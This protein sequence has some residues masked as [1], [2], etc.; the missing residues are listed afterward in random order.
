MISPR[1]IL[2]QAA[3]LMGFAS[4]VTAQI[5]DLP[6]AAELVARRDFAA[7]EVLLD[8]IL[9]AKPGEADALNLKG[10]IAGERGESEAA[11]GWFE[12]ALK[13]NPNLAGAHTNLGHLYRKLGQNSLALNSF[14]Q[15][16][17]LAP[18]DPEALLNA[19]VILADEKKFDEA[20]QTIL[21]IPENLRTPHHW[22]VLGSFQLSAGHAAEA[23][24]TY[25]KVL[26]IDPES[27]ETL[28][29]LSGLALKRGDNK[30]AWNFMAQ[31]RQLA[32]H[33]PQ[34]LYE[35]GYVCLANNYVMDAAAA[36]RRAILMED[37]RPE[38]YAGLIDA[39]MRT[40]DYPMAAPH[41]EK[42]L[43]LRPEDPWG[44]FTKGQLLYLAG[45]LDEAVPYL[46]KSAEMNPKQADPH[47]L[48]GRVAYDKGAN[49]TA[50]EHFLKALQNQP[51]H[52][53][54]WLRLGMLHIRK[55]EYEKAEKELRRSAEL[56]PNEALTHLQLSL[57]LA[58]TGRT[59]EAARETEVHKKLKAEEQQRRSEAPPPLPSL[60]PVKK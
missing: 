17:R 20:G 22:E 9:K 28:R 40:T 24:K 15:A 16:A 26:E 48:L 18:G 27:V 12:K 6:Y 60:K 1:K 36:F 5:S 53:P 52:A 13:A 4:A 7:A 41:V 8:G 29:V 3:L 38:Y 11:K 57:L 23:E 31:A 2:P 58:R 45:K 10:V 42:Y 33:A 19:A 50:E 49:D 35:F 30:A 51:D 56:E 25:R 34:I 59:D 46:Q 21:K 32:P 47:H 14:R 55:Q 39:L 43:H 44:H 37:T 54:S